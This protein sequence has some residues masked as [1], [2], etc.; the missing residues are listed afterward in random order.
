MKYIY[1]ISVMSIRDNLNPYTM[2]IHWHWCSW[3]TIYRDL[4]LDETYLIYY[5]L[6]ISNVNQRSSK[7]LSYYGNSLTLMFL[8]YDIQGFVPGWNIFIIIYISVMSIRDHLNP[9]HTVVIHWH[10]CSWYK[11]I[12]SW[13]KHIYYNLYINHVNQRSSEPLSYCSNSLTLTFLI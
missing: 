5:N 13:M 1:C 3:S 2:V 8:I 6:Y 11:G 7:P 10:W 9:C 12:C 4:F